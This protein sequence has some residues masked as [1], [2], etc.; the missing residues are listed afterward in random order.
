MTLACDREQRSGARPVD[1]GA[2]AIEQCDD[3]ILFSGETLAEGPDARPGY[4]LVTIFAF[5]EPSTN[6]ENI[7]ESGQA[8]QA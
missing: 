6:A 5:A 7:G 8:V 1:D 4:A 3:A 2:A